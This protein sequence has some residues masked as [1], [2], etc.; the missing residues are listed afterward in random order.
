MLSYKRRYL[1][2]GSDFI[3][4]N[5]KNFFLKTLKWPYLTFSLNY[6]LVIIYKMKDLPLHNVSIYIFFFKI[7]LF[8]NVLGKSLRVMQGWT[9]EFFFVRFR[10][11]M[12][13]I[14]TD[15]NCYTYIL[16]RGLSIMNDISNSTNFNQR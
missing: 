9:K 13:L 14:D 10:E 5:I 15:T 1:L 12:L 7:I 6:L 3:Q 2:N 4:K 11:L 8:I 16:F